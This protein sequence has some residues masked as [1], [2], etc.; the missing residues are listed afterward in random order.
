MQSSPR[1][2]CA[3]ALPPA[4]LYSWPCHTVTFALPTRLTPLNQ[5][6]LSLC[7]EPSIKRAFATLLVATSLLVA[8]PQRASG[9]QIFTSRSSTCT[10][11][12]AYPI[13]LHYYR[14]QRYI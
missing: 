7:L 13:L 4:D 1:Y 5:P 10:R 12:T 8:P 2:D 6:I 3:R 11:S 14:Q 9:G